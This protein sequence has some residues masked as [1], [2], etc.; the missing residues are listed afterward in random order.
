MANGP[1]GKSPWGGNSKSIPHPLENMKKSEICKIDS[2]M[3]RLTYHEERE[4]KSRTHLW[5]ETRGYLVR[6]STCQSSR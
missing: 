4:R 6:R 1:T 2:F 5:G 3:Q